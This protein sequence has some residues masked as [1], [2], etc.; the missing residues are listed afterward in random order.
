MSSRHSKYLGIGQ[1][2]FCEAK[3]IIDPTVKR[4]GPIVGAR[5]QSELYIS[6]WGRSLQ[7]KLSKMFKEEEISI[8]F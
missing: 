5:S 8:N 4:L 7:M 2:E 1:C 3:G 6:L